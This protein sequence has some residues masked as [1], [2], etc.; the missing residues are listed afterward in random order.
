[1]EHMVYKNIKRYESIEE[2]SEAIKRAWNS[3]S[4][5]FVNKSI[6]QWRV[7][8]EKVV[9]MNGGHIEQLLC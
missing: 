2:L 7:R 8:M 5:R 3:L 4:Q 6:D 1:M 9:E